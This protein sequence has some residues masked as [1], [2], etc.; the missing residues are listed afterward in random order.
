MELKI[1]FCSANDEGLADIFPKGK[2]GPVTSHLSHKIVAT[3]NGQLVRKGIILPTSNLKTA[4]EEFIK[5][6]KRQFLP[7]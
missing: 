5:M 7:W 3:E 2:I 4:T 6:V 1:G